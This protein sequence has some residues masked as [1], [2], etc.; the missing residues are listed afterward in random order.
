M[1]TYKDRPP[2]DYPTHILVLLIIV[3]ESHPLILARR[4]I[5]KACQMTCLAFRQYNGAKCGHLSRSDLLLQLSAFQIS[6]LR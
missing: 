6:P 2:G 5:S 3:S 1:G 4:N